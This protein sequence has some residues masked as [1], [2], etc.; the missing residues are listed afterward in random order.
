MRLYAHLSA[1]G[2]YAIVLA[3]AIMASRSELL[4]PA[5]TSH[6]P[7]LDAPFLLIRS[8]N[9]VVGVRIN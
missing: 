4:R 6:P 5:A 1:N 9:F 7:V 2:V 8:G 3:D